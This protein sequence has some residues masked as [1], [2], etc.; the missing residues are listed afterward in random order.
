MPKVESVPIDFV[1]NTGG[2]MPLM[3]GPRIP[4]TA[5]RNAVNVNLFPIGGF[6]RRYGYSK[7][8]SSAQDGGVMTG[9]YDASFSSGT[10]VL[11]GTCS[12]EIGT[13]DDLDGTWDDRT[14][15]LTI[16]AGENNL[17][18]FAIL[19]DIVVCCND[20]NTC[21][22]VNSSLTA[23]VLAGSPAFTSALFPVEYRGYMFYGNTVESA[24]RIPDRLRF[25]NNGTPNTFTSTNFID[26]H[27]KQGGQLRGACVHKDRLICFKEN[28][29][30][31]VVFQPT[32]V[33]SDG[34]AF[35]FI[36]NP[37]PILSGVGCM[38]HR[39]IVTFTTPDT[40]ESP[41]E[42]VFFL[43]QYGMPRIYSYGMSVA[44]RIGYFISNCR[45]TTVV[46]LNTMSRTPTVLKS[47]FAVNY[48]ERNQIWLF[49]TQTTQMD[50]VWVLDYTV[51]WAWTRHD[52]ADPFT[53]AAL[54]R[55]TT[56]IYRLFTGDRSGFTYRQDTGDLDDDAAIEWS[57]ETGDVYNKSVSIRNNWP[58][59]EIRG[60]TPGPDENISVSFIPDGNDNSSSI[61]SVNLSSPQPLW[62]SV[63]WGQFEW[64]R[65]GTV[66]RTINP[67]LDAKTLRT[68]F[69]DVD[70]SFGL[71]E[72]F[73]LAP[74]LEGTYYE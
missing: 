66:N 35:P 4:L 57:Y 60:T 48:P 39:T 65:T 16:T 74:K 56:G 10:H 22:Q 37:N 36:Q 62:G 24:T 69:E 64:A 55:H 17:F 25:S 51:G 18:S 8:N 9:L 49:N 3:G 32:R 29:T 34:T 14:G 52:F 27:A 59:C 5:C 71:V 47:C 31:E 23:A 44:P 53:C 21:I 42:Y 7:L 13:M 15:A 19:N 43:D 58:F 20:V 28:N 40:H 73:S 12:D 68:K 26:V 61:N 67:K 45:D 70:G 63:I 30:Y 6:S 11:I 33:A 72:S 41:G 2:M 50:I 54:V 46:T 1:N 38:S